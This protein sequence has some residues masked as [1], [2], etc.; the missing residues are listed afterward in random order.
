M[1]IPLFIFILA[2]LTYAQ[3][4]DSLIGVDTSCKAS[5][6]ISVPKTG[7]IRRYRVNDSIASVSR[8]KELIQSY[9][10]SRSYYNSYV[11]MRFSGLSIMIAGL[12]C[13][14]VFLA[15]K[16]PPGSPLLLIGAVAVGFGE[17]FNL[18]GI[19]DWQ[20]AIVKYNEEACLN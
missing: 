7:F 4:N 6:L 16:S 1:K 3:K 10:E 5:N 13:E 11:V 15:E 9:P 2:I 14:G 17:I 18:I 8:L 20:K 19:S 12:G